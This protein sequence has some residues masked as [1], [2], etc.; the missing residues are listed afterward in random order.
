MPARKR[1]AAAQHPARKRLSLAEHLI[2]ALCDAI[3]N[4]SLDDI[5]TTQYVRWA[6]YANPGGQIDLSKPRGNL[7]YICMRA[8]RNTGLTSSSKHIRDTPEKMKVF[9]LRRHDTSFDA[10]PLQFG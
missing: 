10:P 7:C 3:W 6:E 8:K 2:C 4:T 1:P 9:Q 5:E